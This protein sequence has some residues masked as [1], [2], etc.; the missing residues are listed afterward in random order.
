MRR[1]AQI[2]EILKRIPYYVKTAKV[3]KFVKQANV[4][5]LLVFVQLETLIFHALKDSVNAI[6]ENVPVEN[7]ALKEDKKES[8]K[9]ILSKHVLN[10]KTKV[11][12][13]KTL[14]PALKTS[15]SVATESVI[16]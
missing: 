3:G 10:A 11:I 12:A 7:F 4:S 9:T 6:M 13:N 14:R 16:E 2:T 15:A 8:L 1:A 5:V